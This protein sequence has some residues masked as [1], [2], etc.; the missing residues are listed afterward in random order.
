MAF[1]DFIKNR[2]QPSQE[3]SAAPKPETAKEMYTRQAEQD[4]GSVK[5]VESMAP[6]QQARVEAVK[7]N[8]QKASL[9]V[10]TEA[11]AT[12]APDAT[13][14][15]QPMRQNM[16]SQENAAPDMSPTSAQ[17]GGRA[18]DVEGPSAPSAT[19]SKSQSQA[20]QTVE[21]RPPSWER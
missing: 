2:Q 4:R 6:D 20:P 5:P 17:A 13:A 1:L 11:P 3:T 10:G 21:R 16:M 14:N 15:P 12:S 9:H 8:L 7:S 18:V 19:P